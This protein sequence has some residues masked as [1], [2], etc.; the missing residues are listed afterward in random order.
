MGALI[1]SVASVAGGMFLIRL[2]NRAQIKRDLVV[3]VLNTYQDFL[4]STRTVLRTGLRPE[5]VLVPVAAQALREMSKTTSDAEALD[6]YSGS[7]VQAMRHVFET[8][9]GSTDLDSEER[10]SLEQEAVAVYRGF[11]SDYGPIG[12]ANLG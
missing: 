7:R 5:P 2:E 10:E 6:P 12:P 9:L 1:G 4:S 3:R 8:V 11:V